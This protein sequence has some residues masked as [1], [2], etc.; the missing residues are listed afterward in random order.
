M[1]ES[2]RHVCAPLVLIL[3]IASAT[4]A[5]AGGDANGAIYAADLPSAS[6]C[7]RRILLALFADDTYLFVQRYLCRPWSPSQM[8]T[9]TWR[10]DGESVVLTSVEKET[11]FSRVERGLRYVGNRYGTEGLSLERLN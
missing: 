5:R 4:P 10:G 2:I 6:G 3:V 9:G 7:G 8:E 1:R 11:R